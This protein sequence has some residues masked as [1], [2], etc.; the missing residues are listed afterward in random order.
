MSPHDSFTALR[1][2]LLAGDPDAAADLFARYADRVTAVARSRLSR[3]FRPKVD[4]EDVAQSAF[5][6][7]FQGCA[8]GRYEFA[9][10]GGLWGLLALITLRKCCRQADR[11]GAAARDPA[12]EVAP[13][14][15]RDDSAADFPLLSREPP[16]E[17]ATDLADTVEAVAARLGSPLKRQV[18]EMSLQGYA[19]AE[20]AE[21]LG[22]Y[23][24]GVERVRAEARRALEELFAA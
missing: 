9:D 3:R 10:A 1:V 6:S 21:A 11:L 16:P 4:P 19:V 15:G 5:R 2:G 20:I 23:E 17:A 8:A 24:R 14:G 12:R 22:Y 13:A 7:F 18:F